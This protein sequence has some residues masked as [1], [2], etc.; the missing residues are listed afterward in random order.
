M[1]ETLEN[2]ARTLK[3]M[4]NPTRL[5]ILRELAAGSC[6]VKTICETLDLP[7]ATVSQH[8]ARLRR[9]AI[10]AADRQGAQ[11]CYSL[12]DPCTA[13]ILAAFYEQ[14]KGGKGK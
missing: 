10:V 6:C 11:V 4:G 14:K 2:Q 9:C 3:M 7:Q 5:R 8:L 13:R 1:S 12:A